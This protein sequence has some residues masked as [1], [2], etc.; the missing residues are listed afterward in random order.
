[1]QLCHWLALEKNQTSVWHLKHDMTEYPGWKAADEA[2]RHEIRAAARAF[3]L[4]HSDGLPRNWCA[5]ELL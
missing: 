4:N 3:L 5:N 2:R 1:M